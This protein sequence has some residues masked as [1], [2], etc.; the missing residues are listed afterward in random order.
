MNILGWK[1]QIIKTKK[2]EK[3]YLNNIQE[4]QFLKVKNSLLELEKYF[5]ELKGRELN[6]IEAQDK[7]E[8]EELLFKLI[9][10]STE[11]EE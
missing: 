3:K 9:I 11:N 1:I 8:I 5:M 2:I 10:A 6:D 4:N 7:R